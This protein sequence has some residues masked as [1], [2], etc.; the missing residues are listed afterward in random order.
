M[1]D[2]FASFFR[3]LSLLMLSLSLQ[4]GTA[5]AETSTFPSMRLSGHMPSKA[6]ANAV[7]LENLNAAIDVPVT[8]I[9]PLRH[10]EELEELVRC[11]HDPADQQH[12]GKY[13]TTEEFVE[14]FAPT[15]Q[16]YDKVIAYAK[17]LGLTV[18]NTHPNRTLLNVVGQAGS[19]ETAFNLSLHQY[20]KP[21]GRKF[22]APNNDPEI[23]VAIGSIISGIAGLD[24][25]AV[26]HPH[27]RQ[28]Q[29][30]IG[31][32]EELHVSKAGSQSFPSGPGGGYA[33]ND[34]L[35]AYNL[36][37]VSA[38]GSG[39]NIAL[40]EL[41]GYQA[42]DINAYT[43][44]FGLPAA[45][46]R[47]ILVD[48]GSGGGIDA[49][50]TLDIELALALAPESLI[51]VYEG[52][53]TNQGVLNTYNRI[54]TDNTAK[55]V[56]TSWGIGED[57]ESAQYLQAENAIF[58]QMAAHGQTIYAAA[59][60][61][62]AYDDY[63]NNSSPVVDDPA[64][65]PY[66][67]GV[68][69]TRLTVNSGTCGYASETVWNNGLG[70]GA[71]GGG[72]STFWPIPAWQTNVSNVYSKQKRNVPDVSLNADPNTGYSIYYNGRWTIFGGTSCAAPLWAAFN[73]RVNQARVASQKPVLGFANPILYAIGAGA[74]HTDFHDITSGNNLHYAANTGYDNATG[75]GS[76]NGANL[77]VSLTNPSPTPPP[78][79]PPQLA[80]R[81][82]VGVTQSAPFVKGRIG[83][84][85]IRVANHG[86]GS[87]SGPV[88]VA[89][90]LPKGLAYRSS[91]G[92]GW[93]FKSKTLT[94]THG[95][96]LKPG[97]SFPLITL[98]VDVSTNASKSMI[99][100]A[101][102]SGGG[103]ASSTTTNQVNIR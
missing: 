37:G 10:Q 51:Y 59:G 41:G 83:T 13:L 39:Q 35:I 27:Y 67:V 61:S 76:F 21:S 24:N 56:S 33:P 17:E 100:T 103:S 8:F 82:N 25:H 22:Y 11:I 86:N 44:H 2:S 68:G 88:S 97:A 96:I 89:I 46:L 38:H 63:P 50:V 29:T 84:Y 91:S 80:P 7:F 73:A 26:W 62:G 18:T 81:L 75:W 14:R 64:C 45:K 32:T 48:G 85:V 34:I 3:Y 53:N 15:Q 55:Q 99:L 28:K 1:K 77:F 30:T 4:A 58:L 74:G 42:S 90:T 101:T 6:V 57:Y 71:G 16:D 49:E 92:T 95:N 93:T 102:V 65:Q 70:N 20:Q 66:V 94:F 9:L 5:A 47:N 43:N 19:I 31:A 69:G 79:P 40:F 87:T 60:D 78:P 12:Y 54:A 36:A 98:H 52:P 72:V 23:P